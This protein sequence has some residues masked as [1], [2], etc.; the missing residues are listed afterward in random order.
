MSEAE[1]NKV[2]VS[3]E[4]TVNQRMEELERAKNEWSL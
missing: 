3:W 2:V 4:A 1:I